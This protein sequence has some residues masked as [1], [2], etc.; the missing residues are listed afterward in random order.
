MCSGLTDDIP[1]RSVG[2]GGATPISDYHLRMVLALLAGRQGI[3]PTL[4]RNDVVG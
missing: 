4:Y 2:R 1:P 3:A